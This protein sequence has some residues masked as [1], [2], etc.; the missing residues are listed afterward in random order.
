MYTVY[1]VVCQM[2]IIAII[3]PYYRNI[4]INVVKSCLEWII[5]YNLAIM[6]KLQGLV[7]GKGVIIVRSW[8]REWEGGREKEKGKEKQEGKKSHT[9]CLTE[10]FVWVKCLNNYKQDRPFGI[11]NI[12]E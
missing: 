12:L 9:L 1:F 2:A 10:D 11:T 8:T 4:G 3:A 5:K 6:L 7:L